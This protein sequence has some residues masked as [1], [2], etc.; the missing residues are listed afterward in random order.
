MF[1]NM[2]LATGLVLSGTFV[3]SRT[4]TKAWASPGGR[5]RRN[6]YVAAPCDWLQAVASY[7]VWEDFGTL[8][9]KPGHLPDIMKCDVA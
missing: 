6:D 2:L 1:H 5:R 4:S 9:V 8:S 7:E 3:P